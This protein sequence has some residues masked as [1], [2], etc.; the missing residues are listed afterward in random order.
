MAVLFWSILCLLGF[1][2]LF[3]T[4]LR[5]GLPRVISLPDPKPELPLVSVVVAAR[6]EAGNV[7]G[8]LGA[9]RSQDYPVDKLELIVVDDAS[10]DG[11]PE[12][13]TSLAPDLPNLQIITLR[14]HAPGWS[15]KKWALAQGIDRAQ[16]ELILTTDAD[17][18]PGPSWVRTMVRP[19]RR[20]AVGM[21]AGPTPLVPGRRTRWG[22]A[23]LLDSC[24]QD[25]LIAAGA[26]R[27]MALTCAARN[28][29][30]RN[31]A[32]QEVQ[33]FQGV[34]HII[35]GDDELLMHKLVATG[36][37]EM[38]AVVS[39]EAVVPS[40]PPLQFGAF[41]QQRLRFASKGR[42][43][44]RLPTTLRFRFVLL[45]MYIVNLAILFSI[46]AAL[47][48]QQLSWLAPLA[49]KV[50]AEVVLV[51]AYLRAI[52]VRVRPVTFLLT[53]LLHPLYVV[54]FGTLGS[55]VPLSWKDRRYAART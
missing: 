46:G 14:E 26:S 25:A 49:V 10:T 54:L 19:F 5:L 1:Y 40:P 47:G 11:T 22:E 17:C 13:L 43:Y 53:A 23:L 20:P 48:T 52:E 4:G 28:F 6:N 30:F 24:A 34:E 7:P 32:Y 41:V 18:R 44:F 16:G 21:A 50:V 42:F 38:A 55:L 51:T 37:W 33:G 8:L 36:H 31:A 3:L 39:A 12:V 45:F 27:G 2:L 9:L 15:P 35:S 29:A